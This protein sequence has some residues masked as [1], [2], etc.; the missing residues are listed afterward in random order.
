M[1]RYF[2]CSGCGKKLN[3][4]VVLSI[5]PF[6][7]KLAICSKCMEL[8]YLHPMIVVDFNYDKENANGTQ[9]TI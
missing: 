7:L 4:Y 9:E 8:W 1:R 2:N 3:G 5:H 6:N